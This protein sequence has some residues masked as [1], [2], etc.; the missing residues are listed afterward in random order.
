[1][2]Q[3]K[4]GFTLIEIL[5]VVV[6]LGIIMGVGVAGYSNYIEKVKANYYDSQEEML[7]EAGIDFFTDNR[8]R[9]PQTAGEENCV[10]L[11]T[12][13]NNRYIQT[14][15]DYNKKSC[16]GN[17]SKVCA[18]KLTNTKY[19]YSSYL[20]CGEDYKTPNYK[21][22]KIEFNLKQDKKIEDNKTYDVKMTITY[23]SSVVDS[24]KSG[25]ASYRYVIYKV[26]DNNR[27]FYDTGWKTYKDQTKTE[28][29]ETITLDATGTYKVRGYAYNANGQL[30]EG[31]S[32]NATLKFTLN[33]SRD[34]E[35][36]NNNYT[37]NT[38]VNK[39]IKTTIKATGGISTYKLE[40][41][42]TDSSKLTTLVNDK[43]QS[44]Y[45]DY[46]YDV[47]G[48]YKYRVTANDDLGGSCT[49]ESKEYK[50]DKTKPTCSASLSGG[51]SGNNGWF[52]GGT[53]KYTAT[54]SD[55]L[56]DCKQKTSTATYTDDMNKSVTLK[57]YDNAG[58][59]ANCE[60]K[61]IKIDSTKPTCKISKSGT[62]GDNDWY[63]S[64]VTMKVTGSDGGSGIAKEGYYLSTTNNTGT[65]TYSSANT[66]LQRNDTTKSGTKWYGYVKDDAGNVSSVCDTT[67]WK[68]TVSP[69]CS[70][71]SSTS[72][73]TNQDV[74]L[75]ATCTD[76][77]SGCV[78]SSTS[79]TLS[80]DMNE[81][82][83]FS[84][85]KDNAGNTGSCNTVRVQIDKT[86]PTCAVS[87]KTV[88][89]GQVANSKGWFNKAVN[90]TVGES[91]THSGSAI[92][93]YY[94]TNSSS[95]L[96]QSFKATSD[97]AKATYGKSTSGLTYYGYIKDEAGNISDRCSSN[98][99]IDMIAP[100]C[101]ISYKDK[102]SKAV[103]PTNGWYNAGDEKPIK[104]LLKCSDSG[105]YSG[106]VTTNEIQMLSASTNGDY[107]D[108]RTI[109][110]NAGNSTVCE[111]KM[112]IDNTVPKVDDVS[113]GSNKKLTIKAHDNTN[114]GSG[115]YKYCVRKSGEDCAT[116]WKDWGNKDAEEITTGSSYADGTY[117]VF[118]KDIAGNNSSQFKVTVS[119][120]PN[121]VETSIWNKKYCTMHNGGADATGG[122]TTLS[123][124]QAITRSNCYGN[125]NSGWLGGNHQTDTYANLTVQSLKYDVDAENENNL[126]VTI[127]FKVFTGW[128]GSWL[129]N[130]EPRYICLKKENNTYVGTCNNN[131][132][133]EQSIPIN[134]GSK[135]YG[136]EGTTEIVELHFSIKNYKSNKGRYSLKMYK[137]DYETTCA[138]R[139]K[140]KDD[141][142]FTFQTGY[143][144]EIK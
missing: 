42:R 142:I 86:K 59:E 84:S 129:H 64:D 93:G 113:V 103:S 96:P 104:A 111:A 40:I 9:L 23:D 14:I 6:I 45:Y 28:R 22:P 77:N 116:M 144:F 61:T 143:L 41:V 3:N 83:Q 120:G 95:S 109:E 134:W 108:S 128:V 88:S 29:E 138:T 119:S 16:D 89:G 107:S 50:I 13:I 48:T 4:Y 141:Q 105:D 39:A 91:G 72:G 139:E 131:I 30:A 37:Y 99:K 58:N 90:I 54:C 75:T 67:V 1:M 137:K 94:V 130:N 114:N 18:R 112:K 49:V 78:K 121:V 56:S 25:I 101:N 87:V 74:T 17:K 55:S 69:S 140:F 47:E 62:E 97:A 133:P 46:S 10:L 52:V 21:P 122:S 63:K 71:K 38:W 126:I 31:E 2:K 92:N 33:C 117:Y 102:N 51:K 79:K 132:S 53:V 125:Y 36:I 68:D 81:D 44:G 32:K 76:S 57:V 34:V 73:W 20:S 106:C 124:N 110:D 7:K 65:K 82:Y 100:T 60:A 5:G 115:L 127:K 15:L 43:L 8:G 24:E 123:C 136:D 26:N 12:L 66:A 11:N 118:V 19:I 35:F 27:V 98:L 80:T 85:V 135:N 70:V